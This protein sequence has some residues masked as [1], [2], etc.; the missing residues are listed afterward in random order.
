MF[1][2][3]V[4][5]LMSSL[6]YN[7][8]LVPMDLESVFLKTQE[9]TNTTEV[10]E[11]PEEDPL[12]GNVDD[13]GDLWIYNPNSKGRATKLNLNKAF[14]RSKILIVYNIYLCK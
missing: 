11:E 13:W 10:K 3:V 5:Q 9:C 4:N 2:Y 8:R 7:Y 6:W 1:V 12:A 14:L